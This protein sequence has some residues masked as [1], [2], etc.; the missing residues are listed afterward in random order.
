[1]STV[2]LTTGTIKVKEP[3]DEIHKSIRGTKKKFIFLTERF[4]KGPGGA[5]LAEFVE[6]PILVNIAHIVKINL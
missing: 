6:E 1:M 2:V 5:R 3:L 4:T